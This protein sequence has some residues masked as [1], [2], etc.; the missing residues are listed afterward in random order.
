YDDSERS[1]NER[2]YFSKV[3]Q[4]RGRVG[5]HVNVGRR[6]NEERAEHEPSREALNDR[7]ITTPGSDGRCS[8]QLRACL[9]SQGN[10]V[11]LS[12]TGGDEVMGGV[13]TASP[14]FQDLLARAR[15]GALAHQLKA[16]ALAKRKPW[17]QLFWGAVRDF[18]P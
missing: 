15:F 12:G 4:K 17:F 7:F 3:E 1:W 9:T 5:W 13:P 16:W 6:D 14:E 10:R 8:P 2:S 11:V 18:F